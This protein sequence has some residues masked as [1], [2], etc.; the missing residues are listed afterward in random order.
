[1]ICNY[2][3]IKN[4]FLFIFFLIKIFISLKIPNSVSAEVSKEKITHYILNPEHPRGK[5]K[6]KFFMNF[7]FRKS[8]WKILADSLVKHCNEKELSNV[9]ENDYGKKY[10]VEGRLKTPDK[11]NP[12]VRTIWFIESNE[13]IPKFVTAYPI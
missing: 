1:M 9:K 4:K 3:R 12:K 2:L 8:E 6:S 10:I 7:G 13:Q 5:H 11:R